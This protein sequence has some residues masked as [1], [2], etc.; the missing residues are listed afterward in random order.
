MNRRSFFGLV[1]ALGAWL[2]AP[3]LAL[4][5]TVAPKKTLCIEHVFMEPQE[6]QCLLYPP[7]VPGTV[8]LRCSGWKITDDGDGHLGPGTINY[9]TGTIVVRALG[10]AEISYYTE[11]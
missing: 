10:R 6:P 5:V 11:L 4:P 2:S 8:R 9:L 7:V 1:P 3:T